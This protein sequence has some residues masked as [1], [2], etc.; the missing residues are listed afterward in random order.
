[1]AKGLFLGFP[2]HGHVNPTIG[3]LKELIASGDEITYYCT[4]EFREKIEPTGAKFISYDAIEVEDA[5]NDGYINSLKHLTSI[6]NGLLESLWPN[7]DEHFD[8]MIY[9]SMINIGDRVGKILNID[10]VIRSITTFAFSKKLLDDLTDNNIHMLLNFN[11]KE[12]HN[13][14][15]DMKK[16]YGINFLNDYVKSLNNNKANLNIVFTSEYFQPRK[17]DFDEKYKFIGPSIAKRNESIDFKIE[18]PNNKKI[19]FISLG[20]VANKNINFYKESFKAFKDLDDLIVVLSI[21]KKNNIADL[22]EIP[23]NFLVYNY[24]PQLELLEKIDL[25]IT[26]GGMNSTSEGL[27]NNLPL[28]LVPQFGDQFLVAS[29][30]ENLGAGINLSNSD[31]TSENIL[32]AYKKITSNQK[33]KENAMKIGDSLRNSGGYKK[34]ALEIHNLIE[35]L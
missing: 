6:C 7:K 28:I 14:V 8:Y 26:H 17:I 25:F 30:V 9:D 12:I 29:Q 1:M 2:G 22:G 23:S 27:Y 34:A 18:N 19:I 16:K 32:E 13:I 24:V 21:G 4:E 31:I 15:K 20:T 3:L 11:P 33:F 35:E 10:K 5:T